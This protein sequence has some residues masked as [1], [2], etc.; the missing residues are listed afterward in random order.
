[1]NA[2]KSFFY[3]FIKFF[4]GIFAL[5][6]LNLL[7]VIGIFIFNSCKKSDFE[8]SITGKAN[9]RFRNA[10]ALNSKSIGS[11]SFDKQSIRR[12][13]KSSRISSP[14]TNTTVYMEFPDEVTPEIETSFYNTSSIQ[15]LSDLVQYTDAVIQDEPTENNVNYAIDI[16]VEQVIES[17]NPLVIE[18]K[19]YLYSKGFTESTIQQ[20]I[21]E[22]GGTEQDL[23]AFVMTLTNIENNQ[24]TL[25]QNNLNLFVN[26]TSALNQY[27]KCALVAIGADVLWA[28]TGSSAATWTVA[29]M[30][31]AFSAVAKRFLG[32]IGVAIAVVSFGVCLAES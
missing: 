16:P 12:I 10:L 32:P 18:A 20:M 26:S 25:A 22:N 21:L 27:V 6:T 24:N 3:P 9:A 2:I 19:Q 4:K 7:I 29:M 11:I 23:V 5:L 13:T 1:M 30:T 14:A 17:L 8:N 31:R 15:E 28:L